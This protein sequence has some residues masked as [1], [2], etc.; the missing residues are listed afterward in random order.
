MK[1]PN[2][3]QFSFMGAAIVAQVVRDLLYLGLEN[4]TSLLLAGSRYVQHLFYF[5]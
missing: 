5:I 4:A 2:G 3:E 1:S